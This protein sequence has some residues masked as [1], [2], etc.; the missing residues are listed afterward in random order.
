MKGSRLSADPAEIHFAVLTLHMVT[1]LIL[2]NSD[3]AAWALSAEPFVQIASKFSHG[4]FAV[5]IRMPWFK[6]VSAKFMTALAHAMNLLS[7]RN[8]IHH[9]EIRAPHFRAPLSSRVLVHLDLLDA[10]SRLCKLLFSQKVKS[11]LV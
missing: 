8:L 6:T 11:H 3:F 5:L 7:I 10:D 9:N 1:S 4:V 2:L